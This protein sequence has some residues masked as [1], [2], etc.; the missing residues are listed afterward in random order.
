MATVGTLA[1]RLRNLRIKYTEQISGAE[2]AY[3]E[4]LG[5]KRT[6]RR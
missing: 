4:A 6:R 2:R 5:I 1:E 3:E